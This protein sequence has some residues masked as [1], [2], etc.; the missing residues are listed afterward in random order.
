VH[1]EEVQQWGKGRR[2]LKK[3][4][5]RVGRLERPKR[6]CG[7]CITRTKKSLFF[8]NKKDEHVIHLPHRVGRYARPRI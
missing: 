5:D 7:K 8:R 3:E 1:E 2:C 6:A 4:K